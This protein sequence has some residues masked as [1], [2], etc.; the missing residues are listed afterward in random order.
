MVVLFLEYMVL[1]VNFS[2]ISFTEFVPIPT[3]LQKHPTLIGTLGPHASI[4]IWMGTLFSRMHR[5]V[6]CSS[7]NKFQNF[8]CNC[9]NMYCTSYKSMKKSKKFHLQMIFSEKNYVSKFC[10]EWQ[11]EFPIAARSCSSLLCSCSYRSLICSRSILLCSCSFSILICSCI[12]LLI[13]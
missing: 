2:S 10:K 5:L 13:L 8:I 11:L 3:N 4:N 9:Y 7:L 6:L 12:N 1:S